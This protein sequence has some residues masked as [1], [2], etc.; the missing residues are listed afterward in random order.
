MRVIALFSHSVEEIHAIFVWLKV[1]PPL[2]YVWAA[3]TVEEGPGVPQLWVPGRQRHCHHSYLVPS[4]NPNHPCFILFIKT[5]LESFSSFKPFLLSSPPSNLPWFFLFPQFFSTSSSPLHW[6]AAWASAPGRPQFS[7]P[8]LGEVQG[9][10]DWSKWKFISHHMNN[11]YLLE[12]SSNVLLLQ[13][14]LMMP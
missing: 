9:V 1:H 12:L 7:P 13:L 5:I 14:M 3:H 2:E 4:S 10:V 6:P 11:S 8:W